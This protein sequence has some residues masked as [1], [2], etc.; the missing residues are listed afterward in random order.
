VTQLQNSWEVGPRLGVNYV[1][2]DDARNVARGSFMRIHDYPSINAQSASGAGTQGSGSQVI[3]FRDLYDLNL[4]GIFESVFVT[5]AASAQ[6]PAFLIDPGYHQPFA[7]EWAAGYRRQL[8]G[9]AS[10]DV[11]FINREYRDRTA[12]VEQNGIYNGSV[13]VG[14]A[15]PALN[16]IYL[17][18]NNQWNWPVYRAFEVVATKQGPRFQAVASYTHVWPH[19]AG[20]WQPKDNAAFI[21]PSA[22]PLDRGLGSNDNR[23]ASPVNG[24]DTTTTPGSI[25]WTENILRAS[26][27]YRA[28][29]SFTLSSSYTLQKGRWS[30]PILTRI[31]AADPQFGASTVTLSNGRVVSNPLATTLRFAFPTR[32][33][34]QFV[35]PGLHYLNIRIGREFRIDSVRRF[36]VNVDLFNIP[37][38]GSYQGFLSGANQLFSTNYG[39]GGEVQPPRSTQLELRFWF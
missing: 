17:L 20:T 36:A 26:A 11:G 4:D 16:Q 14:Y 39:R 25:E 3:G 19:L 6:N 33:D 27:V 15:N 30:G 1:L 10:V 21:Q 13:F 28:P 5:P 24:L 32:S 2:T 37:N 38:L 12:T 8:P 34:G 7:D 35:L 22:F 31:A 23:S 29:W 18:T 9:Q